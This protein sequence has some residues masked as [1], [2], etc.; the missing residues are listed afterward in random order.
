[1]KG[2]FDRVGWSKEPF[3]MITLE[4]GPGRPPIRRSGGRPGFPR[5]FRDGAR[6][7]CQGQLNDT[8]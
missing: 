3:V 1:M 7:S 5:A 4:L 6:E 2:P 8:E